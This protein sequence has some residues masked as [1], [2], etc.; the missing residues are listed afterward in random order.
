MKEKI[1]RLRV[2]FLKKLQSRLI[3][4]EQRNFESTLFR[5]LPDPS[6]GAR[7]L[8]CNQ[9]S[10][11]WTGLSDRRKENRRLFLWKRVVR[12]LRGLTT[13]DKDI[14]KHFKEI[15]YKMNK[16]F[17][18]LYCQRRKYEMDSEQKF[19]NHYIVAALIFFLGNFRG[20]F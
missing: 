11:R 14:L 12:A 18:K 8:D 3:S 13:R 10:L 5:Q 4:K 7:Q 6:Q 15:L 2:G 17:S 9:A 20:I 1:K 19:G 16:E